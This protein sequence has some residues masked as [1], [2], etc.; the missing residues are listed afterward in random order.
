MDLGLNGQKKE[1]IIGGSNIMET[2][3]LTREK[4]DSK[5]IIEVF[6]DF[7]NFL[8]EKVSEALDKEG[9]VLTNLQG[10]FGEE[11]VDYNEENDKYF[12]NHKGYVLNLDG[13]FFMMWNYNPNINYF[14]LVEH[15]LKELFPNIE[16]KSIDLILVSNANIIQ[17]LI[18][19]SYDGKI[20]ISHSTVYF[21]KISNN[22]SYKIITIE[23]LNNSNQ[24]MAFFNED[25][26][27][28]IPDTA[29]EVV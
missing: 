24:I 28:R 25:T 14:E 22:R 12:I 16:D 11:N 3:Q 26:L 8:I 23:E 19:D 7:P 4:G 15:N 20:E 29:E 6:K 2:M 17:D 18:K 13:M 21:R 27:I 9:D 10:V 5:I 1:Q